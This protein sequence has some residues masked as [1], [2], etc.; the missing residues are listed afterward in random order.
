MKILRADLHLIT[1]IL[2]VLFTFLYFRYGEPKDFLFTLYILNIL[3]SGS[4][5]TGIFP[6]HRIFVHFKD[7][8]D[9]FRLV[10]IASL[11]RLSEANGK[12]L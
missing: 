10:F 6:I 4:D 1:I 5:I 8:D 2:I 9:L 7:K 11:E 3:T 12:E